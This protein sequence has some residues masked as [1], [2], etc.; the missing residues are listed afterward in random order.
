MRL[1][2]TWNIAKPAVVSR[3]GLVAS[4]HYE[5]SAAGADVLAQGGNA[6]DA[7]VAAGL[8]VGVVEPW[9]S[10]PGGCGFMTVLDGNSGAC[11]AVDFATAAPATLD[12]GDYPLAETGEA[13]DDLFGWPRVQDDRNVEGPLSIAVPTQIAGLAAALARF[14]T[15]PWAEAM[16]PAV[17]LARRGLKLDWHAT[18]RIALEA[19]SLARYPGSRDLFLPGGLPPVGSDTADLATLRNE[20]GLSTLERLRDAGASDFYRGDLAREIA[21][22]M[23][24]IGARVTAAD[25][26]AYRPHILPA[27]SGRYRGA[28]V[29]V[30]PGPGAGPSLLD[31]LARLEAAW[32]PGAARGAPDLA[33]YEACGE[34]LFAAWRHRLATMGGDGGESCTTHVTAVDATG[35]MAAL[36]QT[37][38]SA[39]GSRVTLARTGFLAN[40]GIMW[41][42]PRPGGPNAMAPG[43]R[44]LSNMCPAAVTGAPGG[45]FALGASGGRRIFPAIMQ[46]ISFVVDH[47]MTLEDAFHT[48]R[49]D[50]SGADLVTLD[51][52]LDPA[53]AAA[54]AARW[55]TVALPPSP[56]SPF[57]CPNA[58]RA[59]GD[60]EGALQGCAFV[61]SPWA[62]VA[63][64]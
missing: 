9:M 18:L 39:F 36:T 50:V 19:R 46:L 11:H 58:V 43:R 8:A 51:D 45:D 34:A 14:G 15:L 61:S 63:A 21:R 6:V 23:D 38:L 12:V 59:T 49:I 40:N 3:R 10:G 52:R 17:A 53:I 2:E 57:A 60:G 32:R 30:P 28:T 48:P 31:A 27:R 55:R 7:A 33:A 35:T 62:A 25:L 64:A 56:L 47:G 4:Q 37:L 16:A 1:V 20:R 44:P 13:D 54:L 5:A 41:F 26:A 24:E 42:D 22:D 29:H